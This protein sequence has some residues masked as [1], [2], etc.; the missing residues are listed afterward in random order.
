MLPYILGFLGGLALLTSKAIN[1]AAA[2]QL[3]LMRGTV[4]NFLTGTLVAGTLALSLGGL[5]SG[6]VYAQIPWYYFLAGVMGLVAM[7]LSN[8][9]LHKLPVIHSTALILATQMSAALALDYWLFGI[10]SAMKLLGAGI[11]LGAL[12]WDQALLS[13]RD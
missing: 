8:A 10:G 5:S 6:A 11:I 2:N 4:L 7:L 12:V 1:N 13:R 9:T 3:G